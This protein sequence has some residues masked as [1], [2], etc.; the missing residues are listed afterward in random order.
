MTPPNPRSISVPRGRL[1]QR[2]DFSES[3]RRP[4]GPR[5]PQAEEW[6]QRIQHGAIH[7]EFAAL[8][9]VGGVFQGAPVGVETGAPVVV[10]QSVVFGG[11]GRLP[12]FNDKHDVVF[13]QTCPADP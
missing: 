12:S 11:V 4:S 3:V 2:I 6:L 1:S 8:R 10:S 5:S 13:H 7:P 9:R